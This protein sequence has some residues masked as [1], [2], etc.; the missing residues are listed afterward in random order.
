[1]TTSTRVFPRVD[2]EMK[3]SLFYIEQDYQ[4]F[5][6]DE[7]QRY[8]KMMMKNIQEMVRVR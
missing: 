2:P 5:Q 6:A 8:D 4:R 1:L 3:A 7:Q